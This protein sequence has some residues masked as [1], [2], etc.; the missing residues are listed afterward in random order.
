LGF[1]AIFENTL[2]LSFKKVA[3]AE[4]DLVKQND[5]IGDEKDEM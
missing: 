3:F 2:I 5:E 1:L 4:S